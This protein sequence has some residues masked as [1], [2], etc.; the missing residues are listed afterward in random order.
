MEV[1]YQKVEDC[2]LIRI[3]NLQMIGKLPLSPRRGPLNKEMICDFSFNTKMMC[4]KVGSA[5]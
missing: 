4:N 3:N 1:I 5:L 2:S